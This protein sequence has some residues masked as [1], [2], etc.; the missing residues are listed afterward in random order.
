M[1]EHEH[2]P[3]TSDKEV[4]HQFGYAQQLLRALRARNGQKFRLRRVPYDN[5]AVSIV[6]V[7][8]LPF[9]GK[10][11]K[12]FNAGKTFSGFAKVAFALNR[13]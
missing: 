12:P 5:A 13:G 11:I 10:A 7:I 8:S 6:E 2:A 1:S 3:T 9:D 4:L